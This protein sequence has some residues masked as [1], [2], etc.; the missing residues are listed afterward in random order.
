MLS[1][2]RPQLAHH[3]VKFGVAYLGVVQ[4]EVAVV[5][6]VDLSAQLLDPLLRVVEGT[7]VL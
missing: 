3:R 4:D 7:I 2:E 5:V 1:L 6:V